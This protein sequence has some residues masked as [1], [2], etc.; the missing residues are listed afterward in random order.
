MK[1][2]KHKAATT[3]LNVLICGR[4]SRSQFPYAVFG[5]L[6]GENGLRPQP[7]CGTIKFVTVGDCRYAVNWGIG[8]EVPLRVEKNALYDALNEDHSN[9]MSSSIYDV[10]IWVGNAEGPY[11]DDLPS[12]TLKKIDQELYHM[13][14][15]TKVIIAMIGWDEHKWNFWYSYDRN[16]KFK[17]HHLELN[18]RLKDFE[19]YEASNGTARSPREKISSAREELYKALAMVP[20]P[21][22]DPVDGF[23]T[24]RRFLPLV[25][26][27]SNFFRDGHIILNEIVER[28]N[29]DSPE[30]ETY[31]RDIFERCNR[32]NHRRLSCLLAS[33]FPKMLD[34]WPEEWAEVL[35]LPGLASALYNIVILGGELSFNTIVRLLSGPVMWSNINFDPYVLNNDGQ[36]HREY[37]H[38]DSIRNKIA[39]SNVYT[40][41][42]NRV[43]SCS[44][45]ELASFVAAGGLSEELKMLFPQAMKIIKE[46]INGTIDA[47]LYYKLF[48]F[49]GAAPIPS[50]LS[51]NLKSSTYVNIGTV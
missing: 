28:Y 41:I 45:T 40:D 22:T 5:Y 7:K 35:T 13:S 17:W 6:I 26:E 19:A 11:S 44:R 33:C 23:N 47:P 36:V 24:L 38:I 37:F 12:D 15:Q 39:A 16:L 27:S 34:D 14:H 29:L 18:V 51:R 2:S 49:C 8:G 4:E 46:A 25:M 9:R 10:V 21:T 1:L 32:A 48:R 43:A 50:P 3:M 31:L 42:L 30:H 20:P